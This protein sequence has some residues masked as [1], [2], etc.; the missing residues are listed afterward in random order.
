MTK[1]INNRVIKCILLLFF[2]VAIIFPLCAMFANLANT[3][4]I[5]TFQS[6]TFTDTIINS[7]LSTTTAAIISI[8]LAVI[9]AWF[10]CRSNLKFKKIFVL[11]FTLPMLI[12]SISFVS[13]V[14]LVINL[15]L[16]VLIY[17]FKQLLIKI[18]LKGDAYNMNLNKKEFSVLTLIESNP[19]QEFTQREI[20]QECGI[21]LGTVNSTIQSL[22]E[23]GYINENNLITKNG[24]E[25]LEPY[26][27]KRAIFIAAGF[28]SR[29]V[30][31]TINSPKPLIR[32]NGVR[33]IDTLLDAVIETGIEEIYIV[34][35]YLKEQFDQLLYKYPQIKFIDN[36]DYN[37]ANNISSA[38]AARHLMQN[39]Y[40][41]EADLVLY[42][43]KLITKYQYTSNYLGVKTEMTDDWCFQVDKN[44]VIKKLLVGGRNVYHMYGISYWNEKDGLQLEE[45]IK[46]TY[47]LPGGKERYWDQVSLEYFKN[48]YKLEVRECTFDDIIEIDSYADLKK[49]D[50]H[51]Q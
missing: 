32:V 41:L 23:K 43:P 3:N 22:N 36:L 33:M 14:I 35:G 24:Y 6:S 34:R 28:G 16:K 21:S 20:S 30:P 13:I 4:I 42:N 2:T 9:S 49:I 29:L 8:G 40:V 31:L 46:K 37:E 1:N 5:Q 47:E 10:V 26:R 45:D 18:K 44:R 39:A 19:K 27:V 48:N 38:M 15:I 50:K 11:L 51:Y 25:V 12:P 7:L 17:T